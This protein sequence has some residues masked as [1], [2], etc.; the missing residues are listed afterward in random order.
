MT[1]HSLYDVKLREDIL[2]LLRQAQRRG[3][4]GMTVLGS[5]ALSAGDL[6]GSGA[7]DEATVEFSLG[8]FRQVMEAHATQTFALCHPAS[9]GAAND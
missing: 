3:V 2:G 8:L 7:R 5:L 9:P 1:E 6:I 4:D